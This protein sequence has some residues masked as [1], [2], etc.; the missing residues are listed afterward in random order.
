MA[1]DLCA[2]VAVVMEPTEKLCSRSVRPFL[3]SVLE[4]L[5]EPISCGFQEARQLLEALMDEV[6]RSAQRGDMEEVRK[7]TFAC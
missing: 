2:P 4:V 7:V 1:A 6:C 3:N 5:M